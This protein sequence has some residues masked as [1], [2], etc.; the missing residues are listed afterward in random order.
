MALIDIDGVRL[1]DLSIG[2]WLGVAIAGAGIFLIGSGLFAAL[3]ELMWGVDPTESLG[4]AAIGLVVV[5]VGGAAAH[6]TATAEVEAPC[7]SCGRSVRVHSG[8]EG[9][10]EAVLVRASATPRRLDVGPLSIVH[11]RVKRDKVYCSGE[12]ADRDERLFIEGTPSADDLA[13]T[14]EVVTDGG[15]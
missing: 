9:V 12:C 15:E 7:E 8:R 13:T 2:G 1:R 6:D 11:G 5:L 14:E 4:K 10:D 3:G